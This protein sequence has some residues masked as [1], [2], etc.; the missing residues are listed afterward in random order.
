MIYDIPGVFTSV[1][2]RSY[3]QPLITEG[4]SIL[5]AGFSK[6]GEDKFYQFGDAST[7]EFVLGALDVERYGLGLMYGLGALTKTRH[8]IFK[9]LMPA[10]AN[11]ANLIF[12]SDGTTRTKEDLIDPQLL[13]NAIDLD[14]GINK[15]RLVAK[16]WELTAYAG[17]KTIIWEYNPDNI[18]VYVGGFELKKSEYTAMDGVTIHFENPLIADR[19]INLY[20][21]YDRQEDSAAADDTIRFINQEYVATGN[22]TSI[23]VNGGYVN[24]K[25]KPVKLAVTVNGLDLSNRD[26]TASDG[27]NVIS[28]LL[29]STN[30]NVTYNDGSVQGPTAMTS[31]ASG[32][33]TLTGLT[34]RR[35]HKSELISAIFLGLNSLYSLSTSPLQ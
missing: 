26:F 12:M 2:D 3:V 15:T 31:T 33:I 17:Q 8:V 4:R 29:N 18:S 30:Y 10:D 24:E 19:I 25:S 34:L 7:M 35:L 1:I 32:E 28:G 22:T 16:E 9:R 27:T 5:I 21:M 6:F 23:S 13:K 11:F 14:P 20:T